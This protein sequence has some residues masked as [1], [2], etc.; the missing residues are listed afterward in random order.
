VHNAAPI[1]IGFSTND[2]FK[3][4]ENDM[5]VTGVITAAGRSSRMAP[6]H[7]LIMDIHGKTLIQ[8]S[9]ESLLPFCSKVIIVLGAYPQDILEALKDQEKIEFITNPND[10]HDMFDSVKTGLSRC[11]SDQVLFL[12]GDCPFASPEL[13]KRML[14]TKGDVIVPA[15]K[16]KTGHPI[17]LS[18]KAVV[19]ILH[20]SHLHNL[21]QYLQ[22]QPIVRV[23][24]KAE[25]ILWDIDTHSD[26]HKARI[27]FAKMEGE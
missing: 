23:N 20:D 11:D 6:D 7:K 27:Y 10:H 16:E 8:R 15:Y 5:P 12:P 4:K 17:L 25:S 2:R 22:Q 1:F 26:L 14:K 24:T 18:Q 21:K 13:I 9:L 3:C 19:D